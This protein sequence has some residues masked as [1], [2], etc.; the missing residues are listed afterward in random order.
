MRSIRLP[1]SLPALAASLATA[2]AVAASPALAQTDSSSADP[3]AAAAYFALSMTP[4]G[5]LP[6]AITTRD[7]GLATQRIGFRFQFGYLDDEGDASFH[8]WAG[9]VDLAVGQATL[10]LTA[11]YGDYSCNETDARAAGFTLK[12]K[13]TLMLGASMSTPLL[14]RPLGPAG[15]ESAALNLGLDGAL[16]F[17]KGDL[18]SLASTDYTTQFE[19]SVQHTSYAA[20]VGLPVSLVRRSPGVVIVPML[21]PAVAYGHA[22]VTG[23]FTGEPDQTSSE[24]G[25]RFMLGGGVGFFF[26]RQGIGLQ[27]GAQ[28][29]FFEDGKTVIGVGLTFGR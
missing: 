3:N 13:G 23:K 14:S 21:R 29:V 8:N 4:I 2:L 20:S 24:S 1:L 5:A 18:A 28:K 27:A 7:A 19:L 15:P 11:G 12:C 6:P 10:G 22:K 9:G 26:P 17:G 16:G 25:T